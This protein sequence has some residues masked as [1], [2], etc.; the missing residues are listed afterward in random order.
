M[1]APFPEEFNRRLIS[2][3]ASCHCAPTQL[4]V[5]NLISEGIDKNRIFLT[6]NTIVDALL[7]FRE[8]IINKEIRISLDLLNKTEEIRKRYSQLVL[9]TA[10]RRESFDGGLL[11]IF[12][13]VSDF[14]YKHPD[15]YFFYPVHPNPNVIKA[16]EE[17]EI[18]NLKNIFLMTPVDYKDLIYLL[19]SVDWVMTDSGGIQEEAATLGKRVIIL[20]EF[21]E[22]SECICEGK[23]MLVG[24]DQEKIKFSM[25]EI[26]NSSKNVTNEICYLYGDGQA[27]PK[28]VSILTRLFLQKDSKYSCKQGEVL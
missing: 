23:G 3:I 10:H 7:Y 6:G 19:M 24:T 21:T 16:I 12:K 14:L 11:K 26:Y 5:N 28:I 9:L 15:V 4:S 25:E 8:K 17:S 1:Q 22:R 13:G 20:R 27:V 2:L 18:K